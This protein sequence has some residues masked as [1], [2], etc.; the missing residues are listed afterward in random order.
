VD[1]GNLLPSTFRRF[2]VPDIQPGLQILRDK[3]AR[4]Q[5]TPLPL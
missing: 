5:N 2:S 3:W 1:H 4:I